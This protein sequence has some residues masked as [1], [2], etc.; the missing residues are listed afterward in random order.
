MIMPSFA[1][2]TDATFSYP[3]SRDDF[4]MHIPKFEVRPGEVVGIAGRV[5]S[6]KTTVLQAILGHIVCERGGISVSG[7]IGYVRQNAWLQNVAIRDNILFGEQFEEIKYDRVIHACALELDFQIL[8]NGDL[9]KAGFRGIDL[10]GGQRQL[11]S[12][13]RAAYSDPDLVL[14]DSPLRY[15]GFPL[16]YKKEEALHRHLHRCYLHAARGPQF[17][18]LRASHFFSCRLLSAVPWTT[19]HRT[20]YSSIASNNSSVTKPLSSSLTRS[21]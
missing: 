4:K 12:V 17:R 13:A 21:M 18:E 10:S 7:R 6:G 8:A 20:T 11:V 19:I 16:I 5:G 15:A 3:E 1:I 2:Q 14:L 9:T